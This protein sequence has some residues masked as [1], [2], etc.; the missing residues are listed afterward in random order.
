MHSLS[1]GQLCFVMMFLETRVD[2]SLSLADVAGITGF[3]KF[4]CAWG[5]ID[6]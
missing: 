3:V 1:A 5:M 2:G 4:P 6:H